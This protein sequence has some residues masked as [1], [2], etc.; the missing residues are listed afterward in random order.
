MPSETHEKP[1][2]KSELKDMKVGDVYVLC[3]SAEH[4]KFNCEPLA[5]HIAAN[6][7]LMQNGI[8]N[9]YMIIGAFDS[10]EAAQEF[11]HKKGES[12]SRRMRITQPGEKSDG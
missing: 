12:I 10:Q 3:Y 6:I 11:L 8:L 1:E 2:V 7:E 4:D 9:D 5:T